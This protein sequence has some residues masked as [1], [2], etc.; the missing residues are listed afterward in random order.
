MKPQLLKYL[1]AAQAQSWRTYLFNP[2]IFASSRMLD[3][4]YMGKSACSSH[5]VLNIVDETIFPF[6]NPTGYLIYVFCRINLV[7]GTLRSS[8]ISN[9]S[10]YEVKSSGVKML[11]SL[12]PVQR[13]GVTRL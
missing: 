7:L 6:A 3:G 10:V 1:D 11:E 12:V 2:D 13:L 9:L 8:H 4:R 5:K